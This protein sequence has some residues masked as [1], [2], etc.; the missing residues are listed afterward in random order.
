MTVVVEI[1]DSRTPADIASLHTEMSRSCNIVEIALAVVVVENAQ[2]ICEVSLEEVKMP[3]A[4]VI[5]NAN[6]HPCLF[7]SIGAES[8]SPDDTLFPKRTVVV[9]HEKQAG[10]RVA[11]HIDIGPA[12]LVEVGGDHSHP[13][14]LRNL[15]HTRL[16]AD[17]REAPVTIVSIERMPASRQAAGAALDRNASEIAV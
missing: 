5:A 12:V 16:L 1:D 11:S 13:I 8:D 4:V 3:I 15:R 10:G 6:P 9:V 14:A 17:V 2:V 7:F